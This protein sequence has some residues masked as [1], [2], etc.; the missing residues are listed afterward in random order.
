MGS[1][2]GSGHSLNEL[3]GLRHAAANTSLY[4]PSD[5]FGEVAFFTG[6]WWWWCGCVGAGECVGL[7]GWV[8]GVCRV[9]GWEGVGAAW[10]VVLQG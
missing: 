7:C 9:W 4:G 10:S 5:C 6:G 1:L 8:Y 2:Y 3:G